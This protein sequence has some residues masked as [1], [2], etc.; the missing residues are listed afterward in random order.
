MK[1]EGSASIAAEPSP[2]V[3]EAGEE[4]EEWEEGEW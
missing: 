3:G 2:N 1:K 4:G